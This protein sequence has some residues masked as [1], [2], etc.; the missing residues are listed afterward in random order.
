MTIL[1]RGGLLLDGTGREPLNGG[2]VLIEAD[3]IASVGV[4][5]QVSAPPGAEVIDAEGALITPGMF[6]LHEHISRKILRRLQPGVSFREQ[7]AKLMAQPFEYLMLHSARNALDEVQS[8]VTTIR[9]FGI[10]GNTDIILRRAINEGLIT[11]PRVLASG[12]PI[13]M[14]GGHAHQYSHE[15]DGPNEVRKAVRE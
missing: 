7:G 12:K 4:E 14:T 6:N 15:A 10:P 2:A 5:R 3:R 11:G 13:C 9:N 8:G 1:I